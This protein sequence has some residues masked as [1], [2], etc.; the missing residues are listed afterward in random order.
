MAI[1]TLSMSW[2]ALFLLAVTPG[3]TC[4]PDAGSGKPMSG[5][6]A[7][8]TSAAA[9]Q[10]A[11]SKAGPGEILWDVPKNWK[12][13]PNPNA[14]RIATY[15]VAR[16]DGDPDDGEVSVS[17]VGGSVEANL[18]RW[19]AQF[20]PVKP[21]STKRFERT[22]AGLKVT[23]FETAGSYTGMVVRG[24][25]NK[26]RESWALLAAIVEVPG[27]DPWF[28]KLTGPE[29][30]LTAARPDFESLANSVRPK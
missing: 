4:N 21:D 15:L 26:P 25:Q 14:M 6:P 8:T 30:T 28:F 2:G 11:Q 3:C 12:E 17:R 24:Q 18:S 29:K 9:T 27:G 13:I 7:T 5:G 20:D 22:I 10:T 1:R 16:A 23:I 19:K